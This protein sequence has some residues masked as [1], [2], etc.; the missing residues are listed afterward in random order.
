MVQLRFIHWNTLRHGS[1]TGMFTTISIIAPFYSNLLTFK[2]TSQSMFCDV[3]VIIQRY[4]IILTSHLWLFMCYSIKCILCVYLPLWVHEYAPPSQRAKW[5]GALQSSVP[6]GV[7]IGYIIAAVLVGPVASTDICFHCLCWRWPLLFEWALL[8]PFC[9]AIHFVPSRHFA[10]NVQKIST[11]VVSATSSPRLV[12]VA[13][14]DTFDEPDDI[15]FKKIVP[16]IKAK[17]FAT[18]ETKYTSNPENKDSIS[19]VDFEEYEVCTGIISC[20]LFC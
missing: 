11:G 1:Y 20:R 12:Y 15:E 19:Q 14:Y 6:F 5:M 13:Q 4:D 9:I 2:G 17:S 3:I 16:G 10:V 7:M 8:L 18:V